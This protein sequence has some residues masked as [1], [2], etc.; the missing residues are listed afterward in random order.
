MTRDAGQAQ[1]T[2]RTPVLGEPAKLYHI[3]KLTEAKHQVAD[4]HIILLR[5]VRISQQ[6]EKQL[7]RKV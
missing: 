6:K 5:H 4:Q 1:Y 2:H 7:Y 3:I